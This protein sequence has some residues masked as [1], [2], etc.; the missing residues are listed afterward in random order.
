MPRTRLLIDVL[1]EPLRMAELDLYQWDLLL[2]AARS[3]R[4]LGRLTADIDRFE[5]HDRIPPQVKPHL[6]SEATHAKRQRRIVQW[7]INR[8]TRSLH[9]VDTPLVLL[10]GAAYVAADL[11]AA[12]GR[13]YND[14]DLL[15]RMEKLAAV[16][17]ALALDGWEVSEE[18]PHDEQYFRRWLHELLP[19]QHRHRRTALDVHHNILPRIDHLCFD[20]EKLLERAVPAQQSCSMQ[21]LCPADM[22]IH[23]CVHLFR[24]GHFS[25]GLRDLVDLKSLL[26]SFALHDGF[27]RRLADRIEELGVQVPCYWACRYAMQYLQAPV[28]SEVQT[29]LPGWRPGW[30]PTLAMDRLVDKAFLPGM[31]D[32]DEPLRSV[33]HWIL[34]R[35]PLFLLRK[36]VIPKLERLAPRAVRGHSPR[37]L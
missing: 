20:P 22:V 6:Q 14:V 8:L 34:E 13:I 35:Y 1:Q 23:N 3:T 18:T 11:P 15:V 10:K 19:M 27:G 33:S 16:E 5:L 4:L 30:P 25:T 12:Q 32:H 37:N 26:A 9:R 29:K 24:N 21:V 17:Q 7:E 31:L 2:R 36:S 28:P